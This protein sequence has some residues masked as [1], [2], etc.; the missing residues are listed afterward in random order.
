MAKGNNVY[1]RYRIKFSWTIIIQLC[2]DFYF[3]SFSL[4][5]A[6]FVRWSQD[7]DQAKG[8]KLQ[9]WRMEKNFA[10]RGWGNFSSYLTYCHFI[11]PRW[12]VLSQGLLVYFALLCAVARCLFL[13]LIHF[14]VS[15]S[16]N[17]FL[18]WKLLQSNSIFAPSLT[19]RLA[20]FICEK[21]TK[22]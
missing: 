13:L 17:S 19:L 6:I 7:K 11:E 1:A 4:F 21:I 16:S 9:S 15:S 12:S 3:I 14:F 2:S 18:C 8:E 20:W 5:A 22:L 10:N